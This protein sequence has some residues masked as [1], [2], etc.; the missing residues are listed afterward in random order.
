MR[1]VVV[2]LARAA[3]RRHRMVERLEASCLDYDIHDA[4]DWRDLTPAQKETART[5]MRRDGLD[6]WLAGIATSVSQRAVLTAQ[7]ADGPAVQCMLE[8]DVDLSPELPAV[9]A[10]LEEMAARHT[11]GQITHPRCDAIMITGSRHVRTRFSFC[12]RRFTCKQ[13]CAG[14]NHSGNKSSSCSLPLWSNSLA[15]G[16]CTCRAPFLDDVPPEP[17]PPVGCGWFSPRGSTYSSD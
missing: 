5:S 10:A 15:S 13:D 8:D 6:Y 11:F 14:D 4:T 16:G 3:E 2:S 9:L 17:P 12:F 7:V 1:I